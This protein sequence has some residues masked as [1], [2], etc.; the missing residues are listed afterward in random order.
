MS[1][2]FAHRGWSGLYPENTLL[3][4]QK[5]IE[6]GVDGFE[7]DVQLSRDGEVVVFHDET[8]DR[9]TGY[10]GYLRDLTVSELKRLDASSGFRGL[11][12]KN[13]IPTL[14]EFLELVAPTELIVNMELK[15]N[16]QYYPQL[17]EKVIAL[18]RAFG[19]EKR[20]IFSSFNN[21]SIL[22]CRRLSPEI[23]A[24]F[25]WKGPVIGQAGQYCRDNDVQFFMPDGNYLSDDIVA[26]FRA[27]GIRLAPWTANSLPEI[28]RLADWDVYCIN[29][30]YPNLRK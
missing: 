30:N 24:G 15:N 13:E 22:R 16:R 27:H 5:A 19:M 23:D 29:T 3:A 28:R 2:N 12:G 7:M 14:R 21:V 1:L 20:V 17:E 18:V 11:Y 9:V 6:L 4:F 8:L 26:D 25:L 10:H